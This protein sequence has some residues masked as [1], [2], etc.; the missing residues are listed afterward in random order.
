[1]KHHTKQQNNPTRLPD[2]T[3]KHHTKQQTN[4][5]NFPG[6]K[7]QTTQLPDRPT[8]QPTTRPN[9][10]TPRQT[11]HQNTSQPI[12][13]SSPPHLCQPQATQSTHPPTKQ[14]NESPLP[15]TI[16]LTI[17]VNLGNPCTLWP[18]DPK[19]HPSVP[20]LTSPPQ[21]STGRSSFVPATSCGLWHQQW[22]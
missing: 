8:T 15:P 17:P 18:P 20:T 3:M 16:F 5:T 2:Q 13:S 21:T 4:P 12:S 6:S 22:G 10:E 11:T 7:H 9:N 1:M 14:V 19:D